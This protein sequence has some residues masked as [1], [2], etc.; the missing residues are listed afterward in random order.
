MDIHT[1]RIVASFITH[2]RLQYAGSTLVGRANVHFNVTFRAA[3][4]GKR[5]RY[6]RGS[7]DRDQFCRS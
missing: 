5:N 2:Q 4:P 1:D 3:Y 7:T 6:P